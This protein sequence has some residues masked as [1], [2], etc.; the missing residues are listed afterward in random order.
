MLPVLNHFMQQ[1][2]S[3]YVLCRC[4]A[5]ESAG[6]LVEAIGVQVIRDEPHRTAYGFRPALSDMAAA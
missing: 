5:I 4:R 1:T 3:E 2:G 6:I